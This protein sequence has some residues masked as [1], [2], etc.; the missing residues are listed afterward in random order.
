MRC[1]RLLQQEEGLRE[2]AEIVGAEGLQDADR[3]LMH[4]A[5]RVRTG[6]L[7]QNAYSDV[8]ARCT[9][10]GLAR[11]GGFTGAQRRAGGARTAQPR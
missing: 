8:D 5:E 7:Q 6:F 9:R 2:V 10:R 11:R 3:L 4:T 1:N